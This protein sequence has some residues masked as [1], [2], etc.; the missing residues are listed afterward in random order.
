MIDYNDS[1]LKQN[2][3]Y[4]IKLIEKGNNDNRLIEEEWR[5][6]KTRAIKKQKKEYFAR[7]KEESERHRNETLDRF[8][9]EAEE[10]NNEL[11]NNYLSVWKDSIT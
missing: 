9:K 7:I 11:K 1:I 4:L 3:E 5:E 8:R 2:C 10:S 6:L